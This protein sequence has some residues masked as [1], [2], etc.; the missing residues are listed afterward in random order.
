M[1]DLSSSLTPP[2]GFGPGVVPSSDGL[3]ISRSTSVSM[4]FVATTSSEH[5][6]TRTLREADPSASV[7]T[8]T[9]TCT[10]SDVRDVTIFQGLVVVTWVLVC[11]VNFSPHRVLVSLGPGIPSPTSVKV[12][13]GLITN[14]TKEVTQRINSGGRELSTTEVIYGTSPVV[15]TC[16]VPC[17]YSPGVLSVTGTVRTGVPFPRGPWSN[18]PTVGG[19]SGYWDLS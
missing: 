9:T 4:R 19:T 15:T 6:R 14:T 10:T 17:T 18:R 8:V 11:G 2:E 1:C 5:L 3:S 7:S 12:R 13:S 16:G